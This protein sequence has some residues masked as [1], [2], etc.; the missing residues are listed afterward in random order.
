[1]RWRLPG[2]FQAGELQWPAPTRLGSAPV[3]DYGYEGSVLLPVEIQVPATLAAGGRV[4]LTAEVS[5]LACKEICMPGKAEVTLTLPVRASAN[6]APAARA[7]FRQAQARMPKPLPPG[8]KIEAVSAKESFLL[9]V[10]GGGA[11]QAVFF[12]LEA[13]QI[14]NVTSQ[15]VTVFPGGIR[16]ALRKSDRLAKTPSELTGVL[17]WGPGQAYA[18]AVPVRTSADP[19]AQE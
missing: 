17:E 14:D 13:D 19:A 16:L 10:Q 18:V 15:V 4:T 2:G 5:W 12:P 3:I 6:P 8:W 11:G 7:L 9:T 1:V